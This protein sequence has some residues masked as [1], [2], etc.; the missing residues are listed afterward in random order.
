MCG[1]AGIITR[2]GSGPRD[3]SLALEL[4][5]HRGPDGFGQWHDT[6][7]TGHAV[8]LAH[9]RL[10][11]IDL[12]DNA[13]QPMPDVDGRYWLTF[14]GEI[15]NYVELKAELAARGARFRTSS[16]SEVILEAY[17]AWGPAC[18]DR[19]NG[20]FAF[21]IWDSRERRLFAARDRYGEKPLLYAAKPA[22]FA[23]ASEYKA[24]LTLPGVSR[25]YD[26][27]RLI[28]F[29]ANPGQGCDADRQTVFDDILQL[30]PGEALEIGAEDAAPRVW[31]YYAPRY[32][33]SRAARSEADIFAEFRELLIDSVRIRMRSDVKVGSCLSGGLD[34]SAIVCIA[35]QLVGDDATYHTFTGQFPG[36]DA[37]EAHFAQVVVDAARTESHLVEPTVDRFVDELPSF[38]WLN[39]LPVG[40]ASQFAQWCVFNLAKQH[41]VTVLLD[42][43]GSDEVLG[44]Y[45]TYF[46]LYVQALGE[47]GDGAR[48][49]REV[50]MIEARYPGILA[51]RKEGLKERLPF[52]LRHLMA[53]RL[54]MGSSLYYALKPDVAAR[55]QDDNARARHEGFH[56]LT[57][58][59]VEDSF[60]RFLT[61]LLRYGDRNSMAHSRE[62]RLPFCDHRIADLV[63][64][65]PPHLLMGEAQ[66]KRTLREA[67]R[68]ILPEPIRTRWR[69]QGFNPPTDLWFTS[70]R[71]MALTRDVFAS[72]SFRAS[73]YWL[74]RQWDAMADRVEK[75]ERG[76]GWTLWQPLQLELWKRHFVEALRSRARE[77]AAAPPQCAATSS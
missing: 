21:A 53:T 13:S 57:S 5:A 15:Y 44:G 66:N 19:F 14:N 67:M 39:E 56:A 9:R 54:G 31:R 40:G 77:A 46:R 41:G 37:D 18:L 35:R 23:F 60:G 17:K 7:A 58:A 32:D 42:G 55:V 70:P 63:L 34:S 28:R 45:E 65:L 71:L 20:M 6:A 72:Q 10:S 24:L 22:F 26:E 68:G 29:A 4:M 59:L 43:Q 69:K 48:L 64:S 27:F 61:T 36:T 1:I 25:S 33:A 50:P 12:S 62:V 74:P 49:T 73:P 8:T 2:D 52:R 16:D 76:L 47:T 75:G 51:S 11:I 30:L 38:M 3:L